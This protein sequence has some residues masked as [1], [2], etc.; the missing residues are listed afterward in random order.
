MHDSQIA[1]AL[2]M[3]IQS[4]IVFPFLFIVFLPEG[5]TWVLI[6]FSLLLHTSYFLILGNLYNRGDLI[7]I[8]PAFRGFAPVF[9]KIFSVFFKRLY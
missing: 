8:Y 7:I 9:I 1:I 2:Q 5:I 4:I 3:L 6:I